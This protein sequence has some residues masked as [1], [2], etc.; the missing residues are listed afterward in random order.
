MNEHETG[1]LIETLNLYGIEV[2]CA[3][4]NHPNGRFGW[5]VEDN[6][7]TV[8]LERYSPSFKAWAQWKLVP[9]E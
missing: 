8:K 6:V 7:L 5:F 1:L 2:G 3:S 9:V 4:E